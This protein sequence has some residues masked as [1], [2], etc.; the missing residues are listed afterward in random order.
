VQSRCLPGTGLHHLTFTLAEKI[1]VSIISFDKTNVHCPCYFLEKSDSTFPY[2]DFAPTKLT[3]WLG[4]CVRLHPVGQARPEVQGTV[5]LLPSC[6]ASWCKTPLSSITGRG[7]S[8]SAAA[9]CGG[10]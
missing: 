4:H 7:Y 5:T 3:P 6:R 1:G 9:L 2:R 10:T 8:L